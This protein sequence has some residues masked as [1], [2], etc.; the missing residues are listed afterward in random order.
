M[1]SLKLC[2]VA[3]VFAAGLLLGYLA[4]ARQAVPVLTAA[5]TIPLG[6]WSREKP[7]QTIAALLSDYPELLLDARG[8][9]QVSTRTV[10][11]ALHLQSPDPAAPDAFEARARV[12][13]SWDRPTL[14]LE[15]LK[16]KNFKARI[17]I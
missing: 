10:D 2:G 4:G 16:K 1:K 5:W 12:D 11:L 17:H 8:T 3:L 6:S 15:S 14:H 7:V 9:I 13:G